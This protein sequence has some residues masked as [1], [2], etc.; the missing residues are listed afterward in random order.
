VVEKVRQLE[1]SEEEL[2]YRKTK[3]TS[4]GRKGGGG[5]RKLRKAFCDPKLNFPSA[6]LL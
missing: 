3:Y 6:M 4:K 5:G 2:H 1:V